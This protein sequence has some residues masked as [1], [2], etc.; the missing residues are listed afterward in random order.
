M[1]ERVTGNCI[2]H[3]SLGYPA[4]YHP[5]SMATINVYYLPTSWMREAWGVMQFY[6]SLQVGVLPCL[7]LWCWPKANPLCRTYV[8]KTK[9]KARD[10]Q[11]GTPLWGTCLKPLWGPGTLP[12][13]THPIA[14]NRSHGQTMV[15]GAGSLFCRSEPWQEKE[16]RKNCEEI[17]ISSLTSSLI[18][19]KKRK[20]WK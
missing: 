19:K 14:E 18:K 6:P 16:Q 5:I 13:Y 7:F 11:R 15:D 3:F 12:C 2:S 1:T 4:W 17:T 9:R 10:T 8:P 20:W